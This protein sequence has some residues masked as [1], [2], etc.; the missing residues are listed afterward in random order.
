MVSG[1]AAPTRIASKGQGQWNHVRIEVANQ[2]Y[3]V[4]LNGEKVNDFDPKGPVPERKK[5][6]EPERGPR[7]GSGY[8]GLQNH[9]DYAKDTHVEFKEIRVKPL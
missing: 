9:D 4:Y 5:D 6:F 2:R 1:V 7:P 8:I 3:Q